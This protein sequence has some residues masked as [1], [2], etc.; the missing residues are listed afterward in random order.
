MRILRWS[1]LVCVFALL[2][3]PGVSADEGKGGGEKPGLERSCDHVATVSVQPAGNSSAAT[4]RGSTLTRQMNQ[5]I[6]PAQ[7]T[8]TKTALVMM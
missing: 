3:V 8:T 5:P 1:A 7:I 6:R 4:A 2:V